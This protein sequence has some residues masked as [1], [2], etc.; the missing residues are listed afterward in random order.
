MTDAEGGNRFV[1]RTYRKFFGSD[2]GVAVRIAYETAW[3]SPFVYLAKP[4]VVNLTDEYSETPFLRLRVNP[5]VSHVLN[6]GGAAVIGIR[7][8]SY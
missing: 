1:N 2:P 6:F 8:R 5:D 7:K 4:V 3:A